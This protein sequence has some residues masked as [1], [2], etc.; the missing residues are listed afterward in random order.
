[1][2]TEPEHQ[3]PNGKCARMLRMTVHVTSDGCCM[4]CGHGM[5]AA[6]QPALTGELNEQGEYRVHRV[7]LLLCEG[8]LLGK[9]QECHT[10][11]CALC[12]HD[13]PAPFPI[14]PEL[15]LIVEREP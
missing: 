14:N 12:W 8:C 10:P 5:S 11:A 2:T 15:Y 9:G 13:A 6:S 7:N 1:M 3:C 4:F